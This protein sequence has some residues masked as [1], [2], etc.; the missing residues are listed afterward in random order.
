MPAVIDA[1]EILEHKEHDL[2]EE[3]DLQEEPPKGRGARAGFWPMVVQSMRRYSTH[4]L[5]STSSSDRSALRQLESPMAQL[6]Q[7]HPMLYLLGFFGMNN[8]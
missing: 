7:E 2:Y 1:P 4:R 6:A 8:G 5:Q 3:H